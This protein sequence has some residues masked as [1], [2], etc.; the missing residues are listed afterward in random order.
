MQYEDIC[1]CAA[2]DQIN[3]DSGCAGGCS[4]CDHDHDQDFGTS[5]IV[6]TDAETGEEFVF[7]LVD[8]FVYQDEH[9]CVLVTVEEDEPEMV[10]T[11]VV[12]MDD[13]SEGLVS[14]DD[15]EYDLVYTEYERLCE[16]YDEEEDDDQEDED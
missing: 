12:T 11:R 14:L 7:E 1:N 10:I 16:E 13:G 9:Y 2:D 4:G 8:D 15:S 3:E 5:T 6:M